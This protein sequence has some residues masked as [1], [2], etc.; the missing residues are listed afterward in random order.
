MV[1]EWVA[2]V[3]RM[4][5]TYCSS[6]S[7]PVRSLCSRSICRHSH[8]LRSWSLSVDESPELCTFQEQP[9]GHSGVYTQQLNMWT[10]NNTVFGSARSAR[11]S[12]H[13]LFTSC[14]QRGLVLRDSIVDGDWLP[15]TEWCQRYLPRCQPVSDVA[16]NLE[17]FLV[18]S[19]HSRGMTLNWFQRY[20]VI[21]VVNFHRSVIVA[22]LWRPEVA[23]R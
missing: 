15:A 18:R 9:T 6:V 11:L 22:E 5:V 16:E 2:G 3:L 10:A 8:C 4:P 21:L 13:K 17:R 19:V 7:A 12:V 1:E 23:I 20:R 14:I